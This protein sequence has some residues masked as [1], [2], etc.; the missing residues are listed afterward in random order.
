MT[1]HF[2]EGLV[3]GIHDEDALTVV[4]KLQQMH[5]ELGLMQFTPQERALAQLFWYF[6]DEQKRL[7]SEAV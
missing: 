2:G 1:E 4:S 5:N 6:L 7:L 3:K